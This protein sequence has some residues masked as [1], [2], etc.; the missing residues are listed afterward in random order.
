MSS[1]ERD[2][3]RNVNYSLSGSLI[4][5]L[6][7]LWNDFLNDIGPFPEKC[8]GR[9]IVMCI[10][11]FSYY[12]CGLI[13][14]KM[15]RNT[16]CTLPVEAWYQGNELS[17]EVK[18]EL[19]AYNVVCKNFYEHATSVP[20]GV[21]LKPL[22]IL[23]SSFKEICFIDADNICIQDPELLFSTEPY[24]QYGTIF[25]PDYWHTGTDNP[26]WKIVKSKPRKASEQESGQIVINKEKC[27]RE[28]NLC[29][30]FNSLGHIYHKILLGDKDTFRFA[31]MALK[32]PFYMVEHEVATCGYKDE[33]NN[34]LGVTMVQH[35]LDGNPFF[36]HRN[37]LKWD[38]TQKN[39]IAWRVLKR[40][41]STA[42]TKEYTMGFSSYGHQYLDIMGDVEEKNVD[43][44]FGKYETTC[45][46]Y[47]KEMRSTEAYTNFFIYTY[48]ANKRYSCRDKMDVC[49][50][51]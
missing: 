7:V 13:A 42:Q 43:D 18:H 17:E 37:L 39:E 32:T 50:F 22:A 28:L 24:L 31:W 16:G 11:G 12:T 14:I 49:S 35:G 48:F 23:H 2:G 46:Q 19:A 9:G 41:S 29:M 44:L 10:G 1:F 40:F 51:W 45:L 21:S 33:K 25:W 4:K 8:R 47:L 27:W 34:F 30:H 20:G 38:I 15:L 6:Q 26:I 36:L 3:T 5:E